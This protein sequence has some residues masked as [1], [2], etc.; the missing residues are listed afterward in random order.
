MR[1][2]AWRNRKYKGEELS[3]PKS[4]LIALLVIAAHFHVLE[5]GCDPQTADFKIYSGRYVLI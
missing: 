3:E 2:K 4:Y 1:A 5:E